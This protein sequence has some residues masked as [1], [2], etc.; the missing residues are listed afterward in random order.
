ME[1]KDT[2]IFNNNNNNNNLFRLFLH[3]V[4]MSRCHMC[5]INDNYQAW[6]TVRFP[7]LPWQSVSILPNKMFQMNK[8]D[9]C[10]FILATLLQR[11]FPHLLI[12]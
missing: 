8:I 11:S 7:C 5:F 12:M 2:V 1:Y 4:L 6:Y 10:T 3:N 9:L